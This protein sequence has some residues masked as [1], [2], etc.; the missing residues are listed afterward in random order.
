MPFLKFNLNN[1][2]DYSFELEQTEAT[3]GRALDSEIL[4]ENAFISKKHAMFKMVA[5]GVYEIIDLGGKNGTYVNGVR[6]QRHTLREGDELYFGGQIRAL[7]QQESATV[8]ARKA[9]AK[10][11]SIK[12]AV[13]KLGADAFAGAGETTPLDPS[14]FTSTQTVSARH[15]DEDA[16]KVDPMN[17]IESVIRRARKG[18]KGEDLLADLEHVR[19]LIGTRGSGPSQ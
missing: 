13:R 15:P 8:T 1:G 19:D 17:L 4:I 14:E 9:E 16:E 7:Y 5:P 6:V 11:E 2:S 18:E 3:L 10:G 12:P